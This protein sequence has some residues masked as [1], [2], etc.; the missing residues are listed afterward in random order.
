MGQKVDKNPWIWIKLIRYTLEGKVPPQGQSKLEVGVQIFL[1][2][3]L[4]PHK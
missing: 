4:P 2:P 3:K 1:P